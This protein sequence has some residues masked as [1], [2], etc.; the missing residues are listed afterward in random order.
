[1]RTWISANFESRLHFGQSC[2]PGRFRGLSLSPN[3]EPVLASHR[4]NQACAF[5]AEQRMRAAPVPRYAFFMGRL[6]R[7]GR[8]E[9]NT[10]NRKLRMLKTKGLKTSNGSFASGLGVAAAVGVLLLS[11]GCS[12]TLY[13]PSITEASPNRDGV[14][15]VDL[16]N[17]PWEI[18]S[19]EVKEPVA[20]FLRENCGLA[21]NSGKPVCKN[22][23]GF[24]LYNGQLRN[25]MWGKGPVFMAT[26]VPKSLNAT[27]VA[28]G[29]EKDGDIVRG[30]VFSGPVS[31]L[32]YDGVIERHND[33]ARKCKWEGT[34]NYSGGVVCPEY[35]Y[36]YKQLDV[37]KL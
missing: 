3:G 25:A 2:G 31:L 18:D 29:R 9:E 36:D 15:F 37:S 1:M 33:P 27:G 5:D 16:R 35:G 23:R 34:H 19:K 11:S 12:S 32:V 30:K 10:L 21:E 4:A 8:V 17:G 24:V 28:Q 6:A 7:C 20:R 13:K 26:F 14:F 22:P